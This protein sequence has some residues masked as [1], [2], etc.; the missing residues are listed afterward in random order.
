MLA[1]WWSILI[2]LGA[3]SQWKY[4][5]VAPENVQKPPAHFLTPQPLLKVTLIRPNLTFSLKVG[6]L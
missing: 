4:D 1:P 6:F 3:K 5:W 2:Q